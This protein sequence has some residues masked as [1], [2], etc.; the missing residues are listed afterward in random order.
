M[1]D[2]VPD[3]EP[4][5]P[6]AGKTP[7]LPT[8]PHANWS[9]SFSIGPAPDWV[10]EREIPWDFP[11]D[12]DSHVDILLSDTVHAPDRA[13]TFTRNVERLNTADA[14]QN[15]SHVVIDF[16]PEKEALIVHDVRLWRQG[17]SRS[18]VDPG[19]FLFRQREDA[20]ESQIIH[21]RVSAV[22]ILDDVRSGDALDV[23][24]SRRTHNRLPGE[25]SEIA[26]AVDRPLR[27]AAWYVTV[28]I[29]KGP[30]PY[31]KTIGE[32]ATP[33]E[34]SESEGE[35]VFVWSG[36]R[37]EKLQSEDGVPPW[38]P[39]LPIANL[40]AYSDWAEVARLLDENWTAVAP[41]PVSAD[42]VDP[43]GLGEDLP[44]RILRL[45]R[46]VQD[47]IRYMAMTT[48]L[49]GILPTSP[50]EVI[51]RRYGDCKDKSLL[52]CVLLRSLGVEAQ[53]VLVSSQYRHGVAEF[54]PG[55]S[56]FN[57]AIVTYV[58]DGNRFFADA[59][60]LGAGGDAFSQCLPDYGLG[61]CV[62][63]EARDLMPIPHAAAAGSRWH[64]RENFYIDPL[65]TRNHMDMCLEATGSEADLLRATLL[66]IGRDQF[67]ESEARELQ[68][69]FREVERDPK[70]PL[71]VEDDRDHNHVMVE[72]RFLCSGVSTDRENN[73][74]VFR[75]CARWLNRFL[76]CPPT[77]PPRRHPFQ[78]RFPLA[79]THE[80][81]IHGPV[82][83][84]DNQDML[85]DC[86][87]FRLQS[88]VKSARDRFVSLAFCYQAKQGVVAANSARKFID[89]FDRLVG[90]SSCLA[91]F[92]MVRSPISFA[93]PFRGRPPVL[94]PR[95]PQ[96]R[97][98]F[99]T[100]K[101]FHKFRSGAVPTRAKP[102]GRGIAAWEELR[103]QAEAEGNTNFVHMCEAM[104]RS[105]RSTK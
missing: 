26:F 76:A 21:G 28:R 95:A 1:I 3:M 78:I 42:E 17:V 23:S 31:F 102:E 72:G 40:S 19:R 73:L 47:D 24:F 97:Q 11:Q 71:R 98:S 87:W 10:S 46:F 44:G 43:A 32:N 45:L 88:H 38:Q 63:G 37:H 68:S 48:G 15:L 77:T 89:Y 61:L 74:K 67:A 25:K 13:V 53:P 9:D 2:R 60:A 35:F 39:V 5:I 41:D 79:F 18:Y 75:Y 30:L 34:A 99:A 105:Y 62:S 103:K 91:L 51:R 66:R 96:G 104:I 65:S 50:R 54:L 93:G 56:C 90:L 49:G 7:A 12:S 14:V 33:Y 29:P 94:G 8:T 22:L 92:R 55:L 64:L 101:A 69:F 6:D 27:T 84:W 80:V 58:L 36:S 59:T 82:L 4:A 70:T 16:D 81:V 86:D 20:L 100:D 85:V 83:P 57:H 52:L